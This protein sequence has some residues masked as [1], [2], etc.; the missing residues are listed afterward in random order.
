MWFS[1]LS[2]PLKFVFRH[3]PLLPRVWLMDFP[4]FIKLKGLLASTRDFVHFGA[5]I[6]HR[7]EDCSKAQQLGVTCLVGYAAGAV[8]TVVSNPADVV[9]SS[10]Y[11]KK[12]ENVLQAVKKIG[13]VNLFTRSLPVRITLVGPVVTLQWFFYDTIKVLCG[14]PTSGGLNRQLQEANLSS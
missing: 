7:K 2:K 8:G 14:L 9:V 1:A 11:N 4:N 10:L 6:F 3:S 5:A 12:V 13:L